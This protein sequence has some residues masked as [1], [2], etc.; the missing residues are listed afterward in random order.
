M[1]DSIYAMTSIRA[2]VLPRGRIYYTVYYELD[3]IT[4]M[5]LFGSDG[6]LVLT[7]AHTQ[8]SSCL[9]CLQEK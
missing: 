6:N 2:R 3:A 4:T 8:N 7:S 1:A 5:P 9:N